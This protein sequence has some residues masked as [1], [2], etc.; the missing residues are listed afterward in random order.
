LA[1]LVQLNP[2][3]GLQ[4]KVFAPA[5]VSV[6]LPPAQIALLPETVTV[7]FALMVTRT[8]ALNEQPL[9]PVPVTV[10]SVFEVGDAVGEAQ[11][12]QDRL[13]AGDHK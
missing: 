9:A 3:A 6:V 10:Y 11:V 8:L 4:E 12:A 5:A 13:E 1:Q 2:V 7:G